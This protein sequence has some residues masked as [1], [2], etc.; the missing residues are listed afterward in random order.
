[1]DGLDWYM[2]TAEM[3]NR[4]STGN[5][6]FPIIFLTDEL[7]DIVMQDGKDKAITKAIAPQPSVQPLLI[8]SHQYLT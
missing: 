1:M 7:A 3:D 2:I 4:F 6:P 8:N 5:K